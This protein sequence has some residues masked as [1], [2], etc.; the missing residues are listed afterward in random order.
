MSESIADN[1]IIIP[2]VTSI[3]AAF[4]RLQRQLHEEIRAVFGGLLPFHSMANTPRAVTSQ[5][6]LGGRSHAST[7]LVASAATELPAVD[8]SRMACSDPEDNDAEENMVVT[9]SNS[10]RAMSPLAFVSDCD[11]REKV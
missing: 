9:T 10:K 4:N 6:A 3:E 7:A 5:S 2:A 1:A 8:G 11:C